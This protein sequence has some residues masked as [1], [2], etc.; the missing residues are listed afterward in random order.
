QR[1]AA[2][3]DQAAA[4]VKRAVWLA[5]GTA[6]LLACAC[7]PVA[8][9]PPSAVE[10][11]ITGRIAAHH[12]NDAFTGNLTWRHAQSGDEMLI[13]TPLG[14]GVARIVREG[15]A[16]QLT[17]ADNKQY[18]APD[19]E[20]LTERTLG[21]RLPL[22]GLADWVQGRASAGSPARVDKGPDGK[23][24]ALEQPGWKVEYQQYGGARPALMRLTYQ[25]IELRLAISQWK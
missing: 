21:F 24:R 6:A 16:V 19:A 7:A 11:D 5:V 22:E 10:F 4:A 15:E 3:D 17:T 1:N 23:L 20:S 12:G 14:Q 8:L 25:G 2:E 13:S 9:K 18:S